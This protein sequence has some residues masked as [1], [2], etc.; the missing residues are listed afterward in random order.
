MGAKRRKLKMILRVQLI[1]KDHYTIFFSHNN[2]IMFIL[3]IVLVP[4]RII[5]F[6]EFEFRSKVLIFTDT[7]L[8]TL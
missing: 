4:R 6:R 3:V 1:K 2:T 8:D 7:Q 5:E